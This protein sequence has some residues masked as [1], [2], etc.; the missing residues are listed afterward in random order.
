M[1]KIEW[2]GARNVLQGL[3][4]GPSRANLL[5]T[6]IFVDYLQVLVTIDQGGLRLNFV[7]HL[8]L[9]SLHRVPCP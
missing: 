6:R 7:A 5:C 2:A 4:G 1:L 8:L 9:D 3:V